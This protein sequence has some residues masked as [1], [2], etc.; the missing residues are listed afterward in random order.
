MFSNK[1]QKESISLFISKAFKMTKIISDFG[2]EM[3]S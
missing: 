3:N 1:Y 2:H